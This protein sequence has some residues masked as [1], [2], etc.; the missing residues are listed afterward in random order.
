MA[1]GV[2]KVISLAQKKFR[3][4]KRGIKNLLEIN[5]RK[6]ENLK[7]EEVYPNLD[8]GP[9]TVADAYYDDNVKANVRLSK[10]KNTRRSLKDM[11]ERDKKGRSPRTRGYVA[12]KLKKD[13]EYTGPG[14]YKKGGSVK[15]KCKLGRNRPTKLY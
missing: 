7:I 6:S 11:A 15:A 8:A 2:D 5:A 12:K 1:R 14:K 4:K 9:K 3:S 10:D 13:E